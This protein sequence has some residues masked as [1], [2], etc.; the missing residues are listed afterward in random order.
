MLIHRRKLQLRYAEVAE[1][2]RQRITEGAFKPGEPMPPQRDLAREYSVALSTL[3]VALELLRAEGYISSK[4]GAGTFVTLPDESQR[5][6]VL[7]F[8][9]EEAVREILAEIIRGEGYHSIL[10]SSEEEATALARKQT[11]HLAFVDL[12]RPGNGGVKALKSLHQQ[13]P[14][15]ALVVVC[16]SPDDLKALGDYRIWPVVVIQKPFRTSGIQSA[17]RFAR[18]ADASRASSR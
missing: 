5:L 14:S 6:N 4:Q 7:V 16:H 1:S 10:T 8:D 17:L 12:S 18:V 11:V 3:R 2:I 13:T 15:T 9:G